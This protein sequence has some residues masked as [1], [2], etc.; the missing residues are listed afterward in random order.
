[1]E[2]CLNIAV[3]FGVALVS[4]LVI[5]PMYDIHVPLSVDIYIT[6]WFTLISLVRSYALRRF[7]NYRMTRK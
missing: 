1:M 5:F 2:S 4:Q 7:F 6:L 3:G